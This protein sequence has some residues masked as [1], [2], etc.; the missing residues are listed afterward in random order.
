MKLY[1]LPIGSKCNARCSYCIT[2]FRKLKN[3]VLDV[4][5]L[6]KVL[7][8]NSFDRVE[9]TGGGEPSLHPEIDKIVQ[10]CVDKCPTN[11]Y[12][13]GSYDS[14][15]D[16]ARVCLSRAH[17]ID[18]ENER[19]M[20]VR[21]NIAKYSHCLGLKLS[22]ILH[23]SGIST[24]TEFLEYLNWAKKYA[25]KV[26]VRQLFEY[27]DVSYSDYFRK[28]HVSTEDMARELGRIYQPELRE[29]NYFFDIDGLEIEFEGRSCAC[30][31]NNPVLGA[32]GVL[33]EG[34]GEL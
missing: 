8:D 2:K 16:K 18:K 5:K 17:H 15:T 19:I 29:G 23:K 6:K 31:T 1:V 3:T 20:G 11:I 13:N 28:Q 22:L 14:K 25:S 7:A 24:L 4:D 33:R 27:D 26:V 21:Y 10:I 9:I 32:D 34:W 30:E 12:T